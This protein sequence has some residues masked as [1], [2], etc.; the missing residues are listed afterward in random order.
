MEMFIA[1]HEMNRKFCFSFLRSVSAQSHMAVY[2][3]RI[4][5]FIRFV[6]SFAKFKLYHHLVINHFNWKMQNASAQYVEPKYWRAGLCLSL[7]LWIL[8]IF[9]NRLHF[10]FYLISTVSILHF[11]GIFPAA[12]GL[13]EPHAPPC[14]RLFAILLWAFHAKPPKLIAGN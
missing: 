12:S 3:P 4:F 10:S 13:H 5:F 6:H 2:A 7:W 1:I 8:Y 14:G 9:K 11:L